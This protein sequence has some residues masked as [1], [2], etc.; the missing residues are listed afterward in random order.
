[1][2][3]LCLFW[4]RTAYSGISFLDSLE[5]VTALDYVP[6]DGTSPP[7]S[8]FFRCLPP[9]LHLYSDDVLRARLKTIGVSEYN[10]DMEAQAG[11]QS[12]LTWTIYDV[13]G[14][15]SQVRLSPVPNR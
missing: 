9:Y 8:A 7:L 2:S 5:R 12:A 1:V 15:R 13:G 10:F 4:V 14:T 6:S 3:V 11:K